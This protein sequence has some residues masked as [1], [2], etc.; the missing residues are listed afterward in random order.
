MGGA[1]AGGGGGN[2]LSDRARG[3]MGIRNDAG[4]IETNGRCRS[5]GEEHEIS[6]L[7][8]R[9]C[10][11]GSSLHRSLLAWPLHF[12]EQ[13]CASIRLRG[14]TA[15]QAERGGDRYD[16]AKIDRGLAIRKPK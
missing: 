2:W 4:R 13:R 8:L 15:R 7:D 14:T 10:D 16:F 9:G 5:P 12:Q 1:N 3:R 11:R 6:H